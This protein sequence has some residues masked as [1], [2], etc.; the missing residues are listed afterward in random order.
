MKTPN[1]PNERTVQSYDILLGDLVADKVKSANWADVS[2]ELH[3]LL[4]TDTPATEEVTVHFATGQ[5]VSVK[6]KSDSKKLSMNKWLTAFLTFTDI[7]CQKKP[8]ELS[9]LL[10]YCNRIRELE[11][12][13]GLRAAQFYDRIFRAHRQT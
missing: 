2:I 5:N 11:S 3:Q 4:P 8:L 9:G 12:T 6:P 10:L 7:Y 1:I 13:F